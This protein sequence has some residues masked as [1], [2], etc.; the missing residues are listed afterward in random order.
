MFTK[1]FHDVATAVLKVDEKAMDELAFKI[2]DL[3][4]DCKMTAI[5]DLSD[6][7]TAA[8]DKYDA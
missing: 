8:L 3:A 1:T 7:F 5:N 4:P 6:K 2:L